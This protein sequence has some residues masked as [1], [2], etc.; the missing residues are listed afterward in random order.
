[1]KERGA[2]EALAE[3]KDGAR[4]DGNE[5]VQEGRLV[6][7]PSVPQVDGRGHEPAEAG[8]VEGRVLGGLRVPRWK[9]CT[10]S[11]VGKG[12]AHVLQ[13]GERPRATHIVNL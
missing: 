10:G 3:L 2:V 7:G 5:L 4:G 6:A 12:L 13:G 8:G 11:W 9:P 1:M